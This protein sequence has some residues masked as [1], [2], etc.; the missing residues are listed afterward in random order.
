MWHDVLDR[1]RAYERELQAQRETLPPAGAPLEKRRWEM[2]P[3]RPTYGS[4]LVRG[5][6]AHGS[7]NEAGV[8]FLFGALAVQLGIVVMRIQSDF[9]DCEAMRRVDDD[10]WQ[11]VRIEFEYESRNFLR[12][13][14]DPAQC[15]LIVCWSHNWPDCPCEVVELK[16]IVSSARICN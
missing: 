11:N 2:L 7:A 1:I 16:T 8:V 9:P 4:S 13:E 14:H 10:R 5:P 12:Y 6:L 15:D 3:D